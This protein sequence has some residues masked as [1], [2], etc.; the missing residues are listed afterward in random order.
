MVCGLTLGIP[1]GAL[2]SHQFADVPASNPFH[3]DIDALVDS[4]VT[5]GCG[6]GKYCPKAN[7][8]RE[9][10]AAFLN[11]LG[12][13]GPGK[14]PVVNAKT[15]LTADHAASADS[16]A[17]A[18]HAATAGN[19]D[20]IDG[21]DSSALVMGREVVTGTTTMPN[22]TEDSFTVSCPFGK[23]PVGGGYDYSSLFDENIGPVWQLVIGGSFPT[24]AGWRVEWSN[25]VGTNV[26]L[27]V[28]AIC[29][30]D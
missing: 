23:V 16:A 5:A 30:G 29:V 20:T 6:D 15:A 19:A 8:T 2:A 7:V 28:Y 4:G 13:L 24:D 9:Q 17:E 27:T 3:T 1:L 18:D 10:M 22:G 21:I 11:R 26:S 14:T 25:G 12:A